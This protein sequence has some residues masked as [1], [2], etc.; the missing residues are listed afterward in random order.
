MGESCDG[1]HIGSNIVALFA[2]SARD[3][4]F[5]VSFV[6]NGTDGNTIHF[7]FAG[8]IQIFFPRP[9]L[10]SFDEIF[11]LLFTIC[12]CK[13]EHRDFMCDKLKTGGDGFA[14]LLCRRIFG[15]PFGMLFFYF[16]EL[17]KQ[18]I[19]LFVADLRR[20]FNKVK[21]VVEAYLFT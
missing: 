4:M 2:I 15:Y 13:R 10:H 12:I 14:Y 9:L 6:I 20:M 3:A 11:Y 5:K 17:S 21:I 19:I 1:I 18:T 7:K 16:F 8:E